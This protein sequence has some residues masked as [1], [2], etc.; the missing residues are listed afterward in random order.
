MTNGPDGDG[1]ESEVLC[2]IRQ[3]TING[4]AGADLSRRAIPNPK[5]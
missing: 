2:A 5:D 1:E 4:V 3:L